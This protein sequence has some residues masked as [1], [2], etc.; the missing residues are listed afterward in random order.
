MFCR[1]CG[2]IIEDDYIFCTKCGFKVSEQNTENEQKMHNVQT[3]DKDGNFDDLEAPLQHENE[4]FPNDPQTVIEKNDNQNIEIVESKND[5][6]NL[7]TP[8]SIRLDKVD[9]ENMNTQKNADEPGE[10]RKDTGKM[11]L[12]AREQLRI[13]DVRKIVLIIIS[14]WSILFVIFYSIFSNN[15]GGGHQDQDESILKYINSN[16][17]ED[18]NGLLNLDILKSDSD[19]DSSYFNIA[20]D[21]YYNLTYNEYDQLWNNRWKY[22]KYDNKLL[23]LDSKYSTNYSENSYLSVLPEHYGKSFHNYDLVCEWE[24]NERYRFFIVHRN[25]K[26]YK[27]IHLIKH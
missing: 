27:T 22:I 11:K 17:S 24:D 3:K 1:F 7:V 8:A 10:E 4:S 16:T 23:V 2:N 14:V 19:P 18:S 20:L 15:K 26:S 25:K 21:R 5:S 13:T 6:D 12:S 9:I